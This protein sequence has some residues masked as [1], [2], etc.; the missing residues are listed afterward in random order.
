MVDMFLVRADSATSGRFGDYP[1]S[2]EA[3]PEIDQRYGI[4]LEFLSYAYSSI[5][6]RVTTLKRQAST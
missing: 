3:F 4:V 5:E 1:D 6:D 2:M